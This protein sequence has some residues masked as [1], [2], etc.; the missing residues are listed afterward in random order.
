MRAKRQKRRAAKTK[1]QAA[2]EAKAKAAEAKLPAKAKAQAEL[3][4]PRLMNDSDCDSDESLVG[5]AVECSAA[6]QLALE[7][8]IKP[9]TRKISN[10]GTLSL[11]VF[12]TH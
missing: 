11:N 10:Q 7:R 2:E 1:T 6:S 12:L 8:G 3:A 5:R 9:A 4:M